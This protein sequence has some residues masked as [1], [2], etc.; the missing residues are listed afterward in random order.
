MVTP[1][2]PP[3]PYRRRSP[4]DAH[5]RHRGSTDPTCVTAPPADFRSGEQGLAYRSASPMSSTLRPLARV[6]RYHNSTIWKCPSKKGSGVVRLMRLSN[7]GRAPWTPRERSCSGHRDAPIPTRHPHR[8][9]AAQSASRFPQGRCQKRR[10]PFVDRRPPI[11]ASTWP[12][13]PAKHSASGESQIVRLASSSTPSVERYSGGAPTNTTSADAFP[14]TTCTQS[15]SRSRA[16]SFAKVPS[17]KN[18]GGVGV[19]GIGAIVEL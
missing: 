18:R 11:R 13:S 2:F 14:S 4:L 16:S 7:A 17:T 3:G 10:G 5:H 8:T 9:G 12:S 19:V 15:D 6:S 1:R